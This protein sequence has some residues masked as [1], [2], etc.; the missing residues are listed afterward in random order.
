MYIVMEILEKIK[1]PE[2]RKLEF[3]ESLPK[4]KKIV[5]TIVSFANGAGGELL[6][7]IADK[8]REIV[9][10]DDPFILEE[11]LTSI[12]HDSITPPISPFFIIINIS[13]K[14]LLSVQVLSGSNKPYYA[15]ALGLE[16]G[17]FVRVGSSN[18]M[19]ES[20]V[21]KELQR[22]SRGRSYS[23]EIDFHHSL[24]GLQQDAILS[25]F[26]T[27]GQPNYKPESLVKWCIAGRNNGDTLPTV[28]GLVLFGE[29]IISTYD[30][31]HIRL[32][33]FLGTTTGKIEEGRE[34]SL[35]IIDKIEQLCDDITALLRKE[36]YVEGPR[37]LERTVIP[38][39]AIREAVVNA[40]VHRDY[41]I[42][43]SSIKVNV[44]D[45]RLE[46]ISP[47]ILYG[48]FDIAD[49][50]TGLSECRNRSFVRI[51][52]QLGLMEELGT[53]IARINELCH[54][55]GLPTP[56]YEEQGY[57]FR[58][59]IWQNKVQEGLAEQIEYKLMM[60]SM[61]ASELSAELNIH[62]NTALKYLKILITQGR[63]VK[64]GSGARTRYDI[65]S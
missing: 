38:Y 24:D 60:R 4:P 15:K 21:I 59:T 23:A 61:S 51:F 2:S 62:H 44:F 10:V 14:L 22:Q 48:S 58:V 37:R 7:G 3:K 55:K 40:I 47:G 6:I 12:I 50:G 32:T 63:A 41:S 31:A 20:S 57:F 1:L 11:Q 16:K 34:Y 56:L 27:L 42:T 5:Q 17:V 9:G 45:D 33:R 13:G 19:A 29:K 46:I 8:N 28:T 18:R 35:P 64:R 53:G 52:R 36:S 26:S 65:F 43:S 54:E 30:Y 49:L 25:F 39:F